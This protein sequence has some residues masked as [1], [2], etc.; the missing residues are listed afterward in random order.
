MTSSIA[1]S[2]NRREA[3]SL[4]TASSLRIL[5]RRTAVGSSKPTRGRQPDSRL[6]RR[7]ETP[8][9]TKA[10][11]ELWALNDQG[12]DRPE[13][14]GNQR[15]GDDLQHKQAERRILPMRMPRAQGHN[16]DE[17]EFQ[18]Q[19]CS[20]D[21]PAV[22]PEPSSRHHIDDPIGNHDD[23]ADRLAVDVAQAQ[24]RF[25]PDRE[26]IVRDLQVAQSAVR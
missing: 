16:P 24:A 20:R 9:V 5:S 25:D 26:R 18:H 10:P 8:P 12:P 2:T 1:C 3:A 11:G 15:Q 17:E 23:L 6:G 22:A 4:C 19:R 13:R 14:P 21:R 7:P